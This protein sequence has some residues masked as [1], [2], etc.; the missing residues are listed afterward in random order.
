MCAYRPDSRISFQP[1]MMNR[2]Q[3]GPATGCLDPNLHDCGR[4]TGGPWRPQRAGDG[5]VGAL[6]FEWTAGDASI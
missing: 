5:V 4:R 6:I 3:R 1:C 2:T